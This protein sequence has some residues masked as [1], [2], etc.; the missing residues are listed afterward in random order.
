MHTV[1]TL[2]TAAAVL[3]IGT[4][5]SQTSLSTSNL[6]NLQELVLTES[7]TAMAWPL[8][9]DGDSP[10]YAPRDVGLVA[11]GLRA[12]VANNAS[13]V[14][15]PFVQAFAHQIAGVVEGLG[16]IGGQ[17]V[18]YI[19]GATTP[20]VRFFLHNGNPGVLFGSLGLSARFNTFSTTFHERIQRVVYDFVVPEI[21][22]VARPF[23]DTGFAYVGVAITYGTEDFTRDQFLA[24]AELLIALFPIASVLSFERYEITDTDLIYDAIVFAGE[25]ANVRRVD[26]FRY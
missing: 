9:F 15:Q 4:V 25:G 21:G 14:E 24:D 20:P 13:P 19:G 11:N 3:A 8:A 10:D 12:G 26:L 22:R 1:R 16:F 2:V 7:V 18:A 23:E 17:Q 5:Q 6:P